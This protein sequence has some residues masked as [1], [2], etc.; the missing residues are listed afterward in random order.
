VRGEPPPLKKSGVDVS[1][2]YAGG[3]FKSPVKP[4][5]SGAFI[6]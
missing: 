2:D 3:E 4:H 1:I 5:E 6:V